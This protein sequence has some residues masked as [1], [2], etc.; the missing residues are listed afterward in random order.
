MR[1]VGLILMKPV[2]PN[3]S[4]FFAMQSSGQNL[5]GERNESAYSL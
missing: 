3:V 4:P 5:K 2:K 1:T